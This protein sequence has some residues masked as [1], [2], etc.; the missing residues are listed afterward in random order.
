MPDE[1]FH[2]SNVTVVTA[3]LVIKA[4][5]KHLSNYKTYFGY[6]KNDGFIKIKNLGRVDFY[7]RWETTKNYWLENFRNKDT[8][9]GHSIKKSIIAKDEW[10]AEAYI[11]T[12]YNILTDELFIKNIKQYLTY[13]FNR[14]QTK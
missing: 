11:D 1:L 10:C 7:N 9:I 8:V 4:K 3:V 6:W 12:D 2:N 13:V 5:E 14:S